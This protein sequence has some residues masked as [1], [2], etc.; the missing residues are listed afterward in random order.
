MTEIWKPIPGTNGTYE[1]SS[2]GRIRS[3]DRAVG[4]RWGGTAIK[5]GQVLVPIVD[6]NGYF[7]VSICA[8]NA[9]RR[10][11]VH[12]LVAAAFF[13]GGAG[14][15]NH[16]DFDKTHNAPSNLEWVTH[17]LNQRHAADGQRFSARRNPARAKKMTS[18]KVE[19]LRKARKA[20]AT[21][22]ELSKQFGI[23]GATA[24]RIVRGDIW[25]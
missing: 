22:A 15:V 9:S 5:R 19:E 10:L 17:A 7:T 6:I 20:G 13:P 21:F 1:A 16:K 11:R 18:E 23:S 24:F 3:V 4:H 25:A 8:A 14:E 2:L 12:R